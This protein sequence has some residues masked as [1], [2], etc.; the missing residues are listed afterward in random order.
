MTATLA[1]D[2][3]NF[4]LELHA[5]LKDIDPA[6]WRADIEQAVRARIESARSS[7]IWLLEQAASHEAFATLRS[8]LDRMRRVLT[9]EVPPANLPSTDARKRWTAFSKRLTAAYEEL[10]VQLQGYDIHV[11]SLRPTNY[12]RNAWHFFMAMSAVFVL[13]LIPTQTA[14]TLAA[15]SFA[16]TGWT[17]ELTRRRWP[18]V[19][20]VLMKAFSPVAH[21]HEAHRI[22]SATWYATALVI[23]SLT[24]MHHA[25]LIGLAILGVGDPVAAVVGRR[26]GRTKL[27]NGRS[28]EGSSAFVVVGTGFSAL[29]VGT[30][31]PGLPTLPLLA[32]SAAGATA[33]ALAELFSRRIDDNLTVPVSAMFGAGLVF[34][35][36]GV[37]P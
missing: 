34:S 5:L 27:V 31:Y 6:R 33:G 3:E 29:L 10:S 25:Q 30:L 21:P 19:N 18:Q 9:D 28:L 35:L 1:T 32:A 8:P 14:L 37:A 13:E 22:N 2:S 24:G 7:V 23:M 17:M 36:L 20:R 11:P 4:A 26:Y 12:V 16:V 15:L